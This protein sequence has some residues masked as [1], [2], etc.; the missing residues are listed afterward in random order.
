MV[1][2]PRS[3]REAAAEK[4]QGTERTRGETRRTPD[5]YL[6]FWL[7]VESLK[8]WEVGCLRKGLVCASYCASG[9]FS[10]KRRSP[11]YGRVFSSNKVINSRSPCLL[12]QHS[13]S[14][15]PAHG[16]LCCPACPPCPK[17]RRTPQ[18]RWTVPP[19]PP[20]HPPQERV[21]QLS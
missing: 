7:K 13:F 16:P 3:E 18:R 1:K 10:L 21:E 6:S 4:R 14:P 9:G 19:A 11:I 5:Y 2:A 20:V 15:T 8:H 17:R 12:H